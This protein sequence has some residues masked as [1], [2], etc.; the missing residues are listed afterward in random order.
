MDPTEKLLEYGIL[1]IVVMVLGFVAK[2]LDRRSEKAK[3]DK[4]DASE[5]E[6]QSLRN[7]IKLLRE[8]LDA[9]TDMYVGSLKQS[10]EEANRRQEDTSSALRLIVEE[11]GSDG[12]TQ[13]K[14]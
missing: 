2:T 13:R 1:G 12:F 14:K 8:E 5:A 3:Q 11:L 9:R 10:I 4:D 6:K 7:D